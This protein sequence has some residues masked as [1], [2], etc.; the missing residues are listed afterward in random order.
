MD[1]IGRYEI[2][3]KL[4]QGAM[5]VVYKA[6]DPLIGR[7]VALKTMTH[8]A[9]LPEEQRKEYTKRFFR[10]AQSAGSLQH[11]NIVTIYDM[12]EE[13]GIPFITME[14]VE[15]KSLSRLIEESEKIPLIDAAKIIKQV[16]E[17]LS[18]AHEKGIVHRDI[19]PDNILIDRNGRAVVTDFGI[20]HL[21]ESSLT[22]TGEVLGTPFFMSPEQILEGRIDRR[23]DLFSL[24]VV[25]YL[26][27]TGKRPF[28][29]ETI[30]SICYHIVHSLPDP[31]PDNSI[32]KEL[33][34]IISKLLEKDPDKRY[35]SG[36]ELVSDLDKVIN[37]LS[38][39][40]K[41][42]EI[43]QSVIPKEKIATPSTIKEEVPQK[44]KNFLK[45]FIIFGG[46]F[47]FIFLIAVIGLG[48]YLYKI[49][50][51]FPR[52]EKKETKVQPNIVTP[53]S[54][55]ET[56]VKTQQPDKKDKIGETSQKQEENRPV[57]KEEK[58]G[59]K[60]ATTPP[61]TPFEPTQQVTKEPENK[62]AVK[63]ARIGVILETKIS[64]LS[65]TFFVDG[66]EKIRQLFSSERG[67]RFAQELKLQPG[68]H[69]I[70]VVV[71][72]T[73]FP[74]FIREANFSVDL[75]EGSHQ[76][77]KIIPSRKP[78]PKLT[79]KR[80]DPKTG[81]SFIIIEK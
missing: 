81:Q 21:E 64:E 28:K 65:F 49:N 48:F 43:I 74:P 3:E 59:K 60:E 8:S 73:K 27:V 67:T 22:K 26:L 24:G 31:L 57:K 2:L 37:S 25:F 76:V 66:E 62:P 61:P 11:P 13:N 75:T 69:N 63:L 32:P 56:E 15:G 77:V 35:S 30:S 80:I 51:L 40:V 39:K 53:P 50:V 45:L 17:G 58:K 78:A 7:V 16:A 54:I 46:L 29:G 47:F 55:A 79:I 72:A 23:S 1:K 34:F 42:E 12:G 38:G 6:L 19:K 18:F 14:Y 44:K 41:N 4:G 20:A 10:E 9:N 70:R 33:L 36:K 52:D 71:Q 68:N 5:G